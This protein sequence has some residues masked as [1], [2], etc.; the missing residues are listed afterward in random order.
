MSKNVN[1]AV[2]TV[3]KQCV[4]NFRENAKYYEMDGLDD[5]ATMVKEDAKY[6]DKQLR[7]YEASG[8]L[9]EL[10]NNLVY[11]D[12]L[13]RDEVFGALMDAGLYTRGATTIAG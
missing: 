2:V 12:S 7:L 13:P 10:Y 8:N 4:A 3:L 6:N 5:L 11:Q 1:T 9:T